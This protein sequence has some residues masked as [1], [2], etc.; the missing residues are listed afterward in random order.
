[1][2][3][4]LDPHLVLKFK[5]NSISDDPSKI[6]R[7]EASK[8]NTDKSQNQMPKFLNYTLVRNFE[9]CLYQV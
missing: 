3:L 1:M 7:L 4:P 2:E 8:E 9:K 6:L 5:K